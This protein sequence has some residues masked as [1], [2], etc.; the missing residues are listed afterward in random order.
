MQERGPDLVAH[1]AVHLRLP[2]HGER[3]PAAARAAGGGAERRL[4]GEKALELD[5]PDGAAG[6]AVDV[7]CVHAAGKAR[8]SPEATGRVGSAEWRRVRDSNPRALAG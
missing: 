6:S 2:D 3:E 1:V 7:R 8:S 4:V 5:R